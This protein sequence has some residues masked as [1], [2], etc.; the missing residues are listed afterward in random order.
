MKENTAETMRENTTENMTETGVGAEGRGIEYRDLPET[1]ITRELFASFN[2]R[3]VV[4][5]CW[6]KENG[7]WVIRHA[8]FIDDW[9]AEDYQFLI[10]CLQDTIRAGGLVHGAFENGSLKGFVA[11]L[12]E[13]FGG[14]NRYIDLASL[15]VSQDMRGRGIGRALFLKA[16]EWARQQGAGKLYISA[17]S[18]VESQAFYRGMGCVEARQYHQKHVQEE[19]FDVQMELEL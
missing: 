9:S 5:D 13:I 14:E 1:E 4:S 2:R 15:H 6:R 19:P 10:R 11:V 17:H 12:P 18:A 8:P 7:Q 16:A 3:Q